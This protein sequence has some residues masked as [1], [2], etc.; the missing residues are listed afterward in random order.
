MPVQRPAARRLFPARA[1]PRGGAR[2]RPSDRIEAALTHYFRVGN[3]AALRELALLWLAD[4]VEEGWQRYRAEHGIPTPW[5]TRERIM[6]GLTGG[7][8]ETP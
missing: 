6:V 3:L 8:R 7:R 1:L 4:R 2:R 5:E